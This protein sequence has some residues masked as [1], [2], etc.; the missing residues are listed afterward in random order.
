MQHRLLIRPAR[1]YT[2]PQSRDRVLDAGLALAVIASG[3]L[4]RSGI[5][6]LPQW[7][8]NNGG[9]ALWALMVFVGFGFLFSRASTPLP[10]MTQTIGTSQPTT[11]ASHGAS[12]ALED[13]AAASPVTI[14]D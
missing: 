7:L 5:I 10:Q 2:P 6:P 11:T 9:D 3:L 4:W 8:S 13:C 12:A 14:V 1:K